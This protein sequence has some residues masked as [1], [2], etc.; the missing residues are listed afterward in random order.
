[1]PRN[2]LALETEIHGRKVVFASVHLDHNADP[3][4]RL[5]QGEKLAAE[6]QPWEEGAYASVLAGDFNDVPGSDTIAQFS[7]AGFIDLHEAFGSGPGY[8]ND[9]DDIELN[10]E[11]ASHNQRIDY[12]M[13]RPAGGR[14]PEVNEVALFAD[15]PHRQSD[16]TWLWPSDHIG[17]IATLRL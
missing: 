10:A 6:M 5:A 3:E 11:H 12:L 14:A 17:V 1:M 13:M 7:H 9:R 4:V 16:G 15:R 8:T 2:A